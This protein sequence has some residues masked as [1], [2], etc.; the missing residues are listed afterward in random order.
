MGIRCP[1]GLCNP[2]V[3]DQPTPITPFA[4][5]P[6]P[7][8]FTNVTTEQWVEL[9]AEIKA[10]RKSWE[11]IQKLMNTDLG[12]DPSLSIQ[13]VYTTCFNLLFTKQHREAMSNASKVVC[14]GDAWGYHPDQFTCCWKKCPEGQYSR[15][16]DSNAPCSKRCPADFFERD[17]P[18]HERQDKCLGT[19]WWP[20][21]K[22]DRL[23]LPSSP[24]PV[25]TRRKQS[26][27]INFLLFCH[28]E[29]AKK[30]Q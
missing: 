20:E 21:Y 29:R 22:K 2:P 23:R 8:N 18:E 24:R 7:E 12:S 30:Y 13:A 3:P 25:K 4:Q 28:L 19:V 14:C 10:N 9:C 26:G 16:M 1:G 17:I 15:E 27:S 5:L 11:E 6:H